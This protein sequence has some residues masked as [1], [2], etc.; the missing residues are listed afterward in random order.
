MQHNAPALQVDAVVPLGRVQG[1]PH[2]AKPH[3][4]KINV[5]SHLGRGREREGE[6]DG[7]GEKD[8]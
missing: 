8:K 2:V 4:N 3:S 5:T 1:A 7:E 6:G